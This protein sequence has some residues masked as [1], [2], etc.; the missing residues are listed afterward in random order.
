MCAENNSDYLKDDWSIPF[1]W[2]IKTYRHMNV[3]PS[4]FQETEKFFED[5]DDNRLAVPGSRDISY[6]NYD[7]IQMLPVDSFSDY[8]KEAYQTYRWYGSS[9]AIFIYPIQGLHS[10]GTDKEG[11]NGAERIFGWGRRTVM[12]TVN[13]SAFIR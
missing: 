12:V 2:I 3:S 1:G 13:Y 5:L 8:A 11:I 10:S 9:Q 6:G 7:R 4:D